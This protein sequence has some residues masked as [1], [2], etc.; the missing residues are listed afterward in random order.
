M[1]VDRINNG[2]MLA[3][4]H[5][6]GDSC[7]LNQI[8]INDSWFLLSIFFYVLLLTPIEVQK[9]IWILYHLVHVLPLVKAYSCRIVSKECFLNTRIIVLRIGLR[10]HFNAYLAKGSK[11]IASEPGYVDKR[12]ILCHR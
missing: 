7:L 8:E 5:S 6:D 2:I 9:I 1:G 4:Y 12:H 10:N 11:V 3:S